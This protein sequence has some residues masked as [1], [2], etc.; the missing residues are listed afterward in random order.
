M[1]TLIDIDEELMKKAMDSTGTPTKKE[2]IKIALEE[3]IK[4]KMRQRLKGMAGKELLDISLKDLK[5]MRHKRTKK[6]HISASL[7]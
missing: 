7:N 4:L 2:T 6:H 3:L 5:E 1:K